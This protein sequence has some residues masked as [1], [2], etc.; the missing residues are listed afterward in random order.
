LIIFLSENQKRRVL[1][2]DLDIVRRITLRLVL[3]KR[4]MSVDWIELA[5]DKVGE[6]C[7]DCNELWIP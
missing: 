3:T 6:F 4:G 7:E 2:G 5:Q 1:L